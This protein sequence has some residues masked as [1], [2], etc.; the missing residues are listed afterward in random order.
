M[1]VNVSES[2]SAALA[3]PNNSSKFPNAV[4]V[5]AKTVRVRAGIGVLFNKL[6]RTV[7]LGDNGPLQSNSSV[8][9][10]VVV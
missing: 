5:G 1:A 4:L 3:T 8:V 2:T 10:V 7:N 6:Q 9:V